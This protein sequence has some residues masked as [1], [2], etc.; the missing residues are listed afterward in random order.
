MDQETKNFS[1]QPVRSALGVGV[2]VGAGGGIGNMTPKDSKQHRKH[3]SRA[4]DVEGHRRLKQ[5]S[6]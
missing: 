5:E 1:K 2:A 6:T 3:N 4:R